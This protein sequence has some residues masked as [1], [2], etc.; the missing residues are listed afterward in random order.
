MLLSLAHPREFQSTL[1]AWGSDFRRLAG[2]L[3]GQCFQSTLPAWGSD[4]IERAAGVFRGVSIHAPRVGERRACAGRDDRQ[5][6]VSIHAPRVGERPAPV[7]GRRCASLRFNPR[8]PRGG[9]TPGWSAPPRRPAGFN[10]RSPRG[11]ATF[12]WQQVEDVRKVS[13]HAPR[14]GER[15][16]PAPGAADVRLVSIHAPR[17]GERRRRR[18]NRRP[19]TPRFNPRSPR[20]GATI[21]ARR[22]PA[23]NRRFNPR[24]PRGGATVCEGVMDSERQFQSTLP[25]WG[26][27]VII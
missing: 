18:C 1:P 7:A 23:Y 14:V 15:L 2:S 8:S 5:C 9:A 10:P 24:S 26:S 12:L 21:L 20:G 16:S 4:A 11:G 25:A 3:E 6:G 27:D 13:I 22:P 17:V 19:R